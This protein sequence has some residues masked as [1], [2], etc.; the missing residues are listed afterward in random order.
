MSKITTN[1]IKEIDIARAYA[2][3]LV[4]IGHAVAYQCVNDY[5]NVNY[6]LVMIER[7]I[8]DSY[9]H[10]WFLRLAETIYLFHMP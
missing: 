7:G 4:V 8:T 3:I 1:R 6:D 2:I 9:I 10:H 5:E